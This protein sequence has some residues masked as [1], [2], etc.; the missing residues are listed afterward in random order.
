MFLSEAI[1]AFLV[2]LQHRKNRTDATIDTYRSALGLFMQHSGDILLEQLT[3]SLV[4]SYA[5]Y[6]IQF[7]YAS[8]TY[9]NRLTPI[10]SMV[11]HFYSKNLIDMRPESIDLPQLEETEANFLTHEE[12]LKMVHY[13]RD[14]REKAIVLV[15][16]R[17]GVRV[18]ELINLLTE[19]LFDRSLI[20]RKGKG[21]KSRITFIS[22]DAEKALSRY[23]SSLN[24]ESKYLICGKTGKMLSRQYVNR[25]IVQIAERANIKKKVTPHTM[26]HTCATNLLHSGAR[27]EDVQ[28]ILGH[29]NIRNTLIYMHF[30]N[31]YLKCKYDES[32]TIQLA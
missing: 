2:Y 28:K 15:L 25:L 7:N 9:R 31:D 32:T 16:I 5:D 19:D 3:P 18:S 23:H 27:V 8:K 11:K 6:L 26:R 22:E 24:F 20:V 17:T 30:T 14:L 21:K 12:Q 13:C 10:R 1:E 4:D 29:A